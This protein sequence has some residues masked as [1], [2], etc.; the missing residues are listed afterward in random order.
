MTSESLVS[1][2]LLSWNRIDDVRYV[3]TR[4]RENPWPDKE[5][6][7]VDNASSDGTAEMLNT[8]FPDVRVIAL[9]D[10]IGI[11]GWNAG[12]SA[13]GGEYI[14]VLDDDSYPVG[15]SVSE[16]VSYLT[17][18]PDCGVVGLRIHNERLGIEETAQFSAGEEQTFIGCGAVIRRDVI[19]RI[20]GFDPRL[21]LYEHEMEYSMRVRM[22]GLSV[23][24]LP[25]AV[26]HHRASMKNREIR[27]HRDCRRVYFTSRNILYIM[28][29]HFPLRSIRFRVLRIALG[30][31][32][33]G[34]LAGCGWSALRGV[35][36][37]I[38]LGVQH[39]KGAEKLSD[40]VSAFYDYGRCAGGFF[41]DDPAYRL[42]RPFFIPRAKP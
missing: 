30:R 34:A 9:E 42:K 16:S 2:V 24:F 13:A 20:G 5:I 18:H 40:S 21:F 41:F 26:V 7:V 14:F 31:A 1:F 25:S 17:R 4:L 39:G 38:R 22:A 35:F 11:A 19:D 6:I 27:R 10:N 37:G 32:L 36:A 15:D 28:L 33:G 23:D 8:E 12:L 3:L 29:L